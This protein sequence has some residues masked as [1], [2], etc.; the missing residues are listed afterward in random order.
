MSDNRTASDFLKVPAPPNREPWHGEKRLEAT[1]DAIIRVTRSVVWVA[2]QVAVAVV[3]LR[4]L[5]QWATS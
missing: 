4:Y 3:I 5:F 1:S 2:V